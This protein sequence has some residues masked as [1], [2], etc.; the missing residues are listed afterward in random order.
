LLITT[1]PSRPKWLSGLPS[2]SVCSLTPVVDVKPSNLTLLNRLP[3]LCVTALA[4]V[5]VL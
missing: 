1:V 4:P 3:V 5:S 2:G